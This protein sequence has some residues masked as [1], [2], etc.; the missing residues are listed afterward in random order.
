[1]QRGGEAELTTIYKKI[2]RRYHP[3]G[4]YDREA[5]DMLPYG[6]HL[7]T[8]SPGVKSV[9]YRVDPDH[10]AVLAVLQEHRDE[11]VKVVAQAGQKRSFNLLTEREK[12]AYKAWHSIMGEELLLLEVPSAFEVVDALEKAILEKVGGKHEQKK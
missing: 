2:G 10:A 5:L 6:S 4:E 1:M 9:R 3:I 11:L 7:V 12:R 8:V